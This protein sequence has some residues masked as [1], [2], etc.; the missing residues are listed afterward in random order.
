ML[1]ALANFGTVEMVGALAFALAVT[2]P[3]FVLTGL[4]LRV[5]LSTDVLDTFR[6]NDYLTLRLI[7]T[8]VALGGTASSLLVL[9]VS[10][11]TTL[12]VV[13]VAA[14]KAFDAVGEIYF[15][16][17]QRQGRLDIVAR[18]LILNGVASLVAL[19]VGVYLSGSVVVGVIGWTIVSAVVLLLWNIPNAAKVG[20][21]NPVPTFGGLN[22]AALAALAA[23]AAQ[24]LPATA[25]MACAAVSVAV[26][27][28]FLERSEGLADVGTFTAISSLMLVGSTLTVAVGQ[29]L[30]TKLAHIYARGDLGQFF[31]L[32]R[33]PIYLAILGGLIATVAAA[34]SGASLLRIVYGAE[35]A[36]QTT[37]FTMLMIAMGVQSVTSLLGFATS[38]MRRFSVQLAVQVLALAVMLVA[39][40]TLVGPFG[41][42]GAGGAVLC[43]ALV[44][45]AGYAT[46]VR[47]NKPRPSPSAGL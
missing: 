9:N 12:V 32:L 6:F 2:T 16:H 39:S 28:F 7:M 41:L 38:A 29:P 24:S 34:V 21:P 19:T 20:R 23:L 46:A 45:L 33:P 18:A 30:G 13:A 25:S 40:A 26:P 1:V 42:I 14:G 17:F 3:V 11:T 27:R 15:G 5:L 44:A 43:Q 8:A 36:S 31:G 47:H 37:L 10:R 4:Q 35:Y 22:R